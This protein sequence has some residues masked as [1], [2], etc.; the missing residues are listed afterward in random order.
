[1]RS[2]GLAQEHGYIWR[3]ASP[4]AG[5]LADERVPPVATGE[6]AAKLLRGKLLLE[7]GQVEN[8]GKARSLATAVHLEA[9]ARGIDIKLLSFKNINSAFSQHDSFSSVNLSI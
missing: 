8:E 4:T 9:A 6:K 1:M 3:R 2:R 7:D 5:Y